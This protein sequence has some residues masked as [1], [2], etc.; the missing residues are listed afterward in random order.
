MMTSSHRRTGQY[1]WS[2]VSIHTTSDGI[3]A[4]SG[5]VYIFEL[6]K[7][8]MPE[9]SWV[10]LHGIYGCPLSHLACFMNAQSQWHSSVLSLVESIWQGIP[11][12]YAC[13]A[14]LSMTWTHEKAHIVYFSSTIGF[15]AASISTPEVAASKMLL[16]F[17]WV[18][19]WHSRVLH[20]RENHPLV[21]GNDIKPCLSSWRKQ[22]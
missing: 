21:I 7:C 1:I 12:R 22:E 18:W 14:P 4:D 3:Y 2:W 11:G 9:S 10:R 20:V 19:C 6:M 17:L 15:L 5:V 16:R 8:C 13:F